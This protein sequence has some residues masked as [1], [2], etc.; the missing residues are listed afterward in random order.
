MRVGALLLG[1][2]LVT[3]AGCA[4]NSGDAHTSTERQNHVTYRKSVP[5]E[6][7][8]VM[9]A[10][11]ESNKVHTLG[12][13]PTAG[14]AAAVEDKTT[15]LG[16]EEARTLEGLFTAARCERYRADQW[17]G[18]GTKPPITECPEAQ[19]VCGPLAP[20]QTEPACLCMAP[21]GSVSALQYEVAFDGVGEGQH[22]LFTFREPMSEVTSELVTTLDEI[23]RHHFGK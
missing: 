23:R 21:P 5:S 18:Q 8:F 17:K 12:F 16:A 10:F 7:D 1:I 14:G 2:A 11:L 4:S 15:A 22:G 13:T 6:G 3:L 9:Y 20:G 19:R